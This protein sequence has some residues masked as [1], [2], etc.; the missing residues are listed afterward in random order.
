MQYIFLEVLY[1]VYFLR[2][3]SAQ[4]LRIPFR[5]YFRSWVPALENS[6]KIIH[7]NKTNYLIKLTD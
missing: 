5:S 7:F 6:N 1:I 4:G 3:I 2:W